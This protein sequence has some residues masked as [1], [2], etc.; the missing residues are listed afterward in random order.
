MRDE[1]YERQGWM[2]GFLYFIKV[3]LM[4]IG[5]FCRYHTHPKYL[6]YP[7][8]LVAIRGAI[9]EEKYAVIDVSKGRGS[10]ILEEVEIER[11]L[12]EVYEGGVVSLSILCSNIKAYAVFVVYS[13]RADIY[14]KLL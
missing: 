11:A 7:A 4:S 9:D 1:A 3:L 2:V 8:R 5:L 14:R 10:R 13:S 12:Y 6:P